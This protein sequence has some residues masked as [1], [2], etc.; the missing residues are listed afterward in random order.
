MKK[1]LVESVLTQDR[2]QVVALK[3]HL[4]KS[5][6]SATVQ[7]SLEN[8]DQAKAHLDDVELLMQRM[9]QLHEKKLIH[10]RSSRKLQSSVQQAVNEFAESTGNQNVIG[11]DLTFLMKGDQK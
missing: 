9:E 7:F 1:S 5:M 11:F 6:Q 3:D 2:D 10:E 8:M 4:L